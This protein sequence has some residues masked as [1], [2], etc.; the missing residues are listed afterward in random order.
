[1]ILIDG[2]KISLELQSEIAQ[3]VKDMVAKGKKQ[4]HLAAILV[5][6]DPASQ[7][8]VGS[9]VKA[10]E[11]NCRRSLGRVIRVEL[12]LIQSVN[13]NSIFMHNTSSTFFW[14]F[15]HLLHE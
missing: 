1:M 14:L 11:R 4:P 15:F 10:C 9:K 12:L 5:G 2:K 3:E 8:Y 6:D 7:T 13:G